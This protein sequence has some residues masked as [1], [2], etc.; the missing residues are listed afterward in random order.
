QNGITGSYNAATGVL[1]L[2]GTATLA[3]YEAALR[4][5][6]FQNTSSGPIVAPRTISFQVDDGASQN[7]LSNVATST[8]TIGPMNDAPVITAAAVTVNLTEDFSNS[9]PLSDRV[10][11]GSFEANPN[12]FSGWTNSGF[13]ALGSAHSGS[14]GV[15][16]GAAQISG[17]ATG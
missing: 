5:V 2:S 1:T 13:V 16:T 12:V 3:E 11:N 15:G 17:Q 10:V 4:S 6:T 14:A 9:V 7:N 8:V